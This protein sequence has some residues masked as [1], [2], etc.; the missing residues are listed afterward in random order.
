MIFKFRGR[1]RKG[2]IVRVMQSLFILEIT[3]VLAGSYLRTVSEALL[4]T[5]YEVKVRLT[6]L[7]ENFS[8]L[9][10]RYLDRCTIFYT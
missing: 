5:L 4:Y 9:A 1:D 10:P 3:M 7:F 2:K 6:A 8:I